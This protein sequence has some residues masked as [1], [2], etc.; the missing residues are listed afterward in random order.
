MRRA[1]SKPRKILFKRFSDRLTELN[2]YLP[3]FHGLRASKKI[4]P[5]EL[6]KIILH[7]VTDGWAKQSCLQG[8]YFKMKIYKAT[9]DI[10]ER[11]EV[12]E[13]FY[14]EGTTSKTLIREDAN[15]ASHGRT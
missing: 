6:N 10:F 1:M 14:K 5:E 4:P 7:T 13:I 11:M 2:N 12:M 15:C 3:L 9:C 8:W